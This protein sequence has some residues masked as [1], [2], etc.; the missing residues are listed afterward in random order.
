MFDRL[1]HHITRLVELTEE[2]FVSL[3]TFFVPVKLRRKQYLLKE[4]EVSN[5][6]AFVDKG[7]LRIY[8]VD[9]K[10][11][12]HTVQFAPEG[13]WASDMY[14]NLTG[15]P[16]QY[17]IE[18]LED[19]DLLLLDQEANERMVEAV[20]KMERYLRLILQHNYV[21]THRRLVNAMSQSAEEKYKEF[22]QRY[23]DIVQRVPQHMIASY[24]GITP[25][26]LSRIRGRKSSND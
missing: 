7:L 18:A 9:E 3:K 5:Y 8:T 14:S 12:E 17:T 19:S 13:W 26:F 10:G 2:E 20:P 23:P 1:Y 11:V 21:A 6:R 25:A 24:L 22:V 4:G 15:E 16:S